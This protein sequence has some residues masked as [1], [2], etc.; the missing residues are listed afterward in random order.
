MGAY[1]G[2]EDFVMCGILHSC[3]SCSQSKSSPSRIISLF[4]SFLHEKALYDKTNEWAVG[5]NQGNFSLYCR[6]LSLHKRTLYLV[7]LFDW[8][9]LIIFF[10]LPKK[11]KKPWFTGYAEEVWSSLGYCKCQYFICIFLWS[12]W[13]CEFWISLLVLNSTMCIHYIINLPLDACGLCY[14]WFFS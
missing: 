13:F 1:V 5:E 8:P 6:I 9:S 3:R 4:F 7:V 11:K 12:Q 2:R 14:C 10:P